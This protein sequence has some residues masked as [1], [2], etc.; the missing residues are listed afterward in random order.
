MSVAGPAGVIST[1][2]PPFKPSVWALSG[3]PRQCG[4]DTCDT[5][6]PCRALY[7]GGD[8]AGCQTL[9]WFVYE[10]SALAG[11]E[12]DTPMQSPSSPW[13]TVARSRGAARELRS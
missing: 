10:A 2:G 4:P 12:T 7:R 3:R 5:A 1:P 6:R 11:A 8:G 13:V 9:V